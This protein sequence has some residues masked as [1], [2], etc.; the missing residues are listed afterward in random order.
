MMYNRTNVK[1]I[2]I[3]SLRKNKIGLFPR[4]EETKETTEE[5]HTLNNLNYYETWY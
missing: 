5:N 4:E 2:S 1:K 3:S